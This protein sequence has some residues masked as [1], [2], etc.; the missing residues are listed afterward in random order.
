MNKPDLTLLFGIAL[1][2]V[3]S[4]VALFSECWPDARQRERAESFQRLVGGL[5]FGPTLDL[6]GC[7]FGFDPRLDGSCAE[8]R[9][10]I[11]GGS[12]FC[13]RHASSIFFFPAMKPREVEEK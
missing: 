5:G 6:S 1:L 8:E 12:Y 11:P 3:A 10:P 7:A 2:L 9:G 13:T 4:G